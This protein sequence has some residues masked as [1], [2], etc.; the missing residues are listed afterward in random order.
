MINGNTQRPIRVLQFGEGNFLRAFVDWIIDI[1]NEKGIVNTGVAIVKPRT[2]NSVIID[3]LSKQ[4]Y[5]YHVCLE[6][7]E[8]GE[9][10]Q[11]SRL[12]T[13][14]EDAF[15][16][17]DIEK[18][19]K[20]ILSP[21]LRFVV[22]NTTEA[23][24]RYSKDNVKDLIPIT[25][26]G[27]VTSLLWRRFKYFNG[28]SSKGLFFIPCE[29]IEDNGTT[30]REYVIRH[31][32]EAA[33]GEDF[34]KWIDNSCVFVDTLVDRIVSGA[35]SDPEEIKTRLGNDDNAIVMCE[36]YHFWA[37]GG[38]EADRLRKE[39]PLDA[40]GLNVRFMPSIK[41]FRDRKVRILNGSHT[42]MVAMSLLAGCE[43]VRDAFANEEINSFISSMVNEEVLPVID[44]DQEELKSFANGIL[45]RFL[46][47][48]IRHMLKS[49]A[50]NSLSKWETRN[51]P[52]VR[53]YYRKFGKLPQREL[54]TLAAL[55]A[56]YGPN[57]GFAPEDSKE[58]VN[59]IHTRWDDTDYEATVKAIISGSE[60][61]ENDFEA[62]VPGLI[63]AVA[64]HLGRIRK[65]GV[66]DA[67]QECEKIYS[68]S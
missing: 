43:T 42:G 68:N 54:F 7:I 49:I 34:I 32:Q 24:I 56:L 48:Y 11:E 14:V 40:A 10:K 8:N 1:A 30:L 66:R 60:I 5:N 50:L 38:N 45:E 27:K 29:L 9:P 39:L 2:G 25:F 41:D 51:Y 19:E 46:N 57:S 62:E 59:F 15:T 37:I 26:P 55:L 44:G 16:P 31:A 17:A 58:A 65:E 36:L 13:C 23:G 67:L 20:Y 28:D 4:D 21:D 64:K 12:I 33:L 6:G 52:T 18:Y 47:P 22:S 63:K 61:F 53:D 3:T 35:P